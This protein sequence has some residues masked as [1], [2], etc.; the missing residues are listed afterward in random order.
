MKKALDE[1]LGATIVLDAKDAVDVIKGVRVDVIVAEGVLDKTKMFQLRDRIVDINGEDMTRKEVMDTKDH[2]ADFIALWK[3]TI[4]RHSPDLKF[5]VSRFTGAE[6]EAAEKDIA[7]EIALKEI[8]GQKEVKDIEAA[9]KEQKKEGIVFL[10][11]DGEQKPLSESPEIGFIM[12]L[13][14]LAVQIMR[15]AEKMFDPSSPKKRGS[16]KK[17]CFAPKYKERLKKFQDGLNA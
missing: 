10:F 1:K 17:W 6:L 4:D 3:A 8:S 16:L 9:V 13:G 7:E 11:K 15:E 2:D 12:D 14:E 5:T